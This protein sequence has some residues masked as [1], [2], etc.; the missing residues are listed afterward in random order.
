MSMSL[1]SNKLSPV[2][3]SAVVVAMCAAMLQAL[4]LIFMLVPNERLMGPVQRIFYFHVGSAFACYCSVAV[5]LVAG[6]WYLGTRNAKADALQASAG[7]VGLVFCTIVLVSGM[8]WGKAAWNI[9]FSWR[10][11]RLV[12]FLVLWLIFIGFSMLRRF[13]DRSR[14][15]AHS[16]VLSIVGAITVP[17]VVYS[18]KF[19]SHVGQLHPVV[20]ENRG[21]KDPMF[22]T[23]F[24]YCSATLVFLQFV[25]MWLRFRVA[26]VEAEIERREVL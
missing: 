18:V 25:L 24:W 15:G 8:I 22:I 11:P 13:G 2:I 4:Y 16:A 10:E 21:L 7:E 23:A 17:V 9:A 1:E 19:L 12:S 6:L 26:C 14:V 5:M 20:V 3:G